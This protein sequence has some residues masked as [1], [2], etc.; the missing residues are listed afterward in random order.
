MAQHHIYHTH[1]FI[2]SSRASGEANKMLSIYT[3][4]LGLVRAMAGGIRLAKSK[5]RYTLQDMSYAKIDLV[6]GRDIWRVTSATTISSFPL[7]RSKKES[8]VFMSRVSALIDRLCRGEEGNDEVFDLIIQSFLLLD[9]E[10]FN[11]ESLSALELHTV[12]SIVHSLGYVGDSDDMHDYIGG[13]FDKD[14]IHKLLSEK[15]S[16][17]SHINRALRESGL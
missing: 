3:R 15:K 13:I 14:K 16:I 6:K 9:D 1:G 7:A 11:H 8:I 2:I 12:L 10:N 17:I 4:E 5:L